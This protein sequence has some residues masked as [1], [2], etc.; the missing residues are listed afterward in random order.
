MYSVL[1]FACFLFL[2]VL[3][4]FRRVRVACGV[5]LISFVSLYVGRMCEGWVDLRLL[6]N[7]VHALYD[8]FIHEQL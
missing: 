6:G 7:T 5:R 3:H 2:R 4:V 8:I 1:V